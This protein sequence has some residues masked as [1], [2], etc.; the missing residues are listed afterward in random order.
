[1]RKLNDQQTGF[2]ELKC[3]FSSKR[4]SEFKVKLEESEISQLMPDLAIYVTGSFARFEANDDSDIDLFLLLDDTQAPCPDTSNNFNLNSIRVKAKLIE[5]A[6][7]MGFPEFS[8]DGEFLHIHRLTEL[9]NHL[10]GREDDSL[11]HFTARMLLL[12][13]SFPVL[14]EKTYKAA[15][16]HIVEAYFR[17]YKYH[18]VDFRP[19]FL[20]NDIVRFWKTL[21]LNYENKRNQVVDR[22]SRASKVQKLKNFKLKYS[23]LFTC[24]ATIIYIMCKKNDLNVDSTIEMTALTPFS[25]IQWAVN[26]ISDSAEETNAIIS[27]LQSSYTDCLTISAR[28][29]EDLIVSFSDKLYKLHA[30]E[31]A[32]AF[33]LQIYS[34]LETIYKESPSNLGYL[35]L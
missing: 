10:G 16:R 22:N 33:G 24:Y 26:K 6:E 20:L 28:P 8:N 15:L 1:M 14:G 30:F 32:E 4:L 5:I 31:K 25:R 3:D 11:N 35:I 17:D 19:S 21:C 18:P 7:S 13:E 27:R 12:L 9:S 2:D 29:K 34:I 23:R